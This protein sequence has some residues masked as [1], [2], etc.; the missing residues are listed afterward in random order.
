MTGSRHMNGRVYDPQLGRF[1]SVD[2][3]F[4]FPT[5]TQSLNPYSY[6]LNSPLTLTDPT[7]LVAGGIMWGEWLQA[8]GG[9]RPWQKGGLQ[10]RLD[11]LKAWAGVGDF[12]GISNIGGVSTRGK[13]S[14]SE[15]TEVTATPTTSGGTDTDEERAKKQLEIASRTYTGELRTDAAADNKVIEKLDALAGDKKATNESGVSGNTTTGA[16]GPVAQGNNSGAS[17]VVTPDSNVVGHLHVESEKQYTTIARLAPG[18]LDAD[19]LK[20]GRVPYIRGPDKSV[21][22]IEVH[23]IT[24]KEDLANGT[25]PSYQPRLVVVRSGLEVKGARKDQ[26]AREW[27]VDWTEARSAERTNEIFK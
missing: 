3:V 8:Q 19:P 12:G 24:S 5:N 22:K 23:Q 9:N 14:K 15:K 4:Q 25:Q 16:W 18:P 17:I 6:V 2:P 13:S 21:V 26:L 20:S 1:L 10:A 27:R 11:D 7:G